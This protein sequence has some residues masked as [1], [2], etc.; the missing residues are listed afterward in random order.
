MN[1]EAMARVRPQRHRKKKPIVHVTTVK[2]HEH[3]IKTELMTTSIL[4]ITLIKNA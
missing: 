4:S 2:L 3:A 1:D